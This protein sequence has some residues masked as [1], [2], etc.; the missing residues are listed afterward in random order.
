MCFLQVVV[1][2]DSESEGGEKK[3]KVK[4]LVLVRGE[5]LLVTYRYRDNFTEIL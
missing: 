4:T 3:K 1:I 5:S 2:S